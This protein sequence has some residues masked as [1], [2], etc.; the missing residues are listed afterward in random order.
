MLFSCFVLLP[1]TPAFAQRIL[2]TPSNGWVWMDT[3][4]DGVYE[5]Y[6][7][8]FDYLNSLDEAFRLQLDYPNDYTKNNYIRNT[9]DGSQ[10]NAAAQWVVNGVVQ[11]KTVDSEVHAERQTFYESYYQQEVLKYATLKKVDTGKKSAL[12]AP[13]PDQNAEL[14]SLFRKKYPGS[15]VDQRILY[16][17]RYGYTPQTEASRAEWTHFSDDIMV[18]IYN[19][20]TANVLNVLAG[21]PAPYPDQWGPRSQFLYDWFVNFLKSRDWANMSEYDRAYGV[22]EYLGK[23]YKY[24][25]TPSGDN[26]EDD[27]AEEI[28]TFAR[29]VN[30][31]QFVCQQFAELYYILGTSVGLDV[32][33][34]HIDTSKG[35]YERH[36]FNI[37]KINGTDYMADASGYSKYH[38]KDSYFGIFKKH[39][40]YAKSYKSPHFQNNQLNLTPVE[41]VY[42]DAPAT[43]IRNPLGQMET[44]WHPVANARQYP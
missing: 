29:N 36:V 2:G 33:F 38:T 40:Y 35:N 31:K 16:Y 21:R 7:H 14:F 24:G 27:G 8:N 25:T 22:Y 41:P 34:E 44:I 13:S 11:T 3:N 37:I 19:K 43:S 26:F 30:S 5:C 42:C 10:I 23:T 18:F 1:S 15:E 17:I 6:Y 39:F 12:T 9:P 20:P 4:A 32:G 28:S